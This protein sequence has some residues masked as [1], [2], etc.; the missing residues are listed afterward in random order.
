MVIFKWTVS[1]SSSTV[2][3]VLSTSLGLIT[4]LS[5][6]P[7]LALAT[8]TSKGFSVAVNDV[9]YF[10]SPY[11]AGKVSFN[12]SLLTLSSA[13]S[14]VLGFYPVTIVQEKIGVEELPDLV[15]NYTSKDDVFQEEFLIG[16]FFPLAFCSVRSI[17]CWT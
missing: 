4:I 3:S 2:H 14:S 1:S 9:D 11:V 12:V 10:V 8:F 15:K 17:M 5:Y 6:L 13:S 7:H 16:M